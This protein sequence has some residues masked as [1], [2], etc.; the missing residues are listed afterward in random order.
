V[1]KVLSL[2]AVNLKEASAISVC[3][4][5]ASASSIFELFKLGGLVG[6]VFTAISYIYLPAFL[7]AILL[8]QKADPPGQ[9]GIIIGALLQTYVM[10]LLFRL[11]RG[12]YAA[13]HQGT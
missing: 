3:G 5:L 8:T 4:L 7:F 1:S 12:K 2:P 11:I 10:Y 6:I 13:N 9:I